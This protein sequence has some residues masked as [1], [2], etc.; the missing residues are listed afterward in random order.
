MLPALT[1]PDPERRDSERRDSMPVQIH[2][3]LLAAIRDGRL[4]DG[5]KL[6]SSRAAAEGLGVSRST[7]NTA[8]DL[9]RAEGVLRIRPGAAPEVVAPALPAGSRRDAAPP[10]LSR[11][12]ASLCKDPRA[13]SYGAGSGAMSPGVPA[14]AQFPADEWAQALRRAARRTHGELAAYAEP[15]GHPALRRILA[16]R[17]RADRGLRVGPEQILITT[18]TQAALSLVAQA[19]TDPGETAAMEDPGYPGARG[20]FLGAGLHI[21][22]VPTDAEGIRV[23]RVPREA[24][25]IYVTPSN[26]YPLGSRLSLARRLAL[27]EH[28]RSRSALIL[29][30]DY[31]SEFLWRGREIAALAAHGQGG[32]TVYLGSAAKVLMPGLRIG[33]MAVPEALVEPLRQA[34]RNL[35]LLPNLHAQLALADMMET[36]RYR[37]HLRRISRAY[38]ALGNA[39]YEALARVEGI[40]VE[41]P[42][43]GV[44]LALRL[45]DGTVERL[46]VEALAARGFRPARLSA[47]SLNATVSGLIVG[48]ADATPA[49]IAD[50]AATLDRVTGAGARHGSPHR[51]S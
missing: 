5:A 21:A 12:G 27:L 24:R 30:D 9:L 18:G 4:A 7:V 28:A 25:L 11:R 15:F 50:F 31:D 46:A 51:R 8:Y 19:M 47:C 3:D 38:E 43:G 26:Q 23:D 44:Q 10:G 40:G 45:R 42:D 49:L 48:F 20:A 33:W 37:A 36:G 35:G 29:E 6:P 1:R 16:Q 22:P 14:E 39:L 13:R 32:E 17:L 34:Q 2:R 41:P